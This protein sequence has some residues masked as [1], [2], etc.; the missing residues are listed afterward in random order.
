MIKWFKSTLI[1]YSFWNQKIDFR[2]TN[3]TIKKLHFILRLASLL[4]G[5]TFV[6]VFVRWGGKRAVS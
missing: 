5:N 6:C 2:F 3:E 1:F 4:P